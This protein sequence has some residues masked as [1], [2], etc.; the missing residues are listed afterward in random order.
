MN[1]IS[2]GQLLGIAPLL[3]VSLL[4]DLIIK[5]S[6]ILVGAFLLTRCLASRSA[7]AR[8]RIWTLTFLLLLLLPVTSVI[9]WQFGATIPE[10][11]LDW[12]PAG[13]VLTLTQLPDA[14][15]AV[16]RASGTDIIFTVDPPPV[17]VPA[18][19]QV[20]QTA[21]VDPD[22]Y[23]LAI[24]QTWIVLTLV[25]LSGVI[26][27][28]GRMIQRLVTERKAFQ[29]SN[30]DSA[31]AIELVVKQCARELG[32]RR[33]IEVS[34]SPESAIPFV[35]GLLRKHLV[36]P[37]SMCDWPVHEMQAVIRHELAHVSRHDIGRLTLGYLVNI[38]YWYNPLMWKAKICAVL[39]M[40]MAS[41]D[42]ACGAGYQSRAYARQLLSFASADISSRN[43]N[44]S[45]SLARPSGLEL[46]ML[47]ILAAR[48]SHRRWPLWT[49]I[50]SGSL[51]LP[52]VFMLL[53][54]GLVESGESTLQYPDLQT[55]A[56]TP[57]ETTAS[58]EPY[59]RN[60]PIHQACAAGD[61][62]QVK[63]LL[64]NNPGQLCLRDDEGMTP[65]ACAA[66][67]GH[68]RTVEFLLRAGADPDRKNNNGLTPLFCAV[69]RDRGEL[70]RL[71]IAHG[72][73]CT[74][75]GYRGRSLLHMA[76]RCGDLETV[77]HLIENGLD[78]NVHDSH[79]VT[80]LDLARGNRHTA[81]ADLILA[82]GGQTGA[83]VGRPWHN[84]FK[85][86]P[87]SV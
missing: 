27:L 87:A 3:W 37:T 30:L 40:E 16:S 65:L 28:T 9:R 86:R 44:W 14:E 75:R 55:A 67:N 13:M 74:T 15:L 48:N 71:L 76:A 4:V 8:S 31:P 58:N 18:G 33:N 41:D 61:L 17:R 7:A 46:R 47:N 1:L 73:D 56:V 12:L 79:D 82:A 29:K 11:H 52:C 6:L 81:V 21:T 22:G 84:M 20:V 50:L 5:G 2:Q 80:P 54:L 59:N 64:A 49:R 39:E 62:E 34:Y 19:K 45:P 24:G 42:I 70:T 85:K 43:L 23:S 69:D 63:V 77:Q 36:L 26:V 35:T 78:V 25:W 66:W 10:K 53:G 83:G 57:A 60:I 32:L 38:L 68:L 72:A 51:C